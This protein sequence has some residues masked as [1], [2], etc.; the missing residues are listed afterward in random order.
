MLSIPVISM[1]IEYILLWYLYEYLGNP[2]NLTYN[3]IF[4]ISFTS[5]I[6]LFTMVQ[7]ILTFLQLE[8]QRKQYMP[9]LSAYSPTPGTIIIENSGGGPAWDIEVVIKSEDDVFDSVKKHYEVIYAKA[10]KLID[11][12]KTWDLNEVNTVPVT[13]D[14]SYF[15]DKEKEEKELWQGS[16]EVKAV[17]FL[18]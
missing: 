13:T 16:F 6:V 5:A 15:Y 7:I 12:T 8:S 17:Y 9:F 3:N 2:M 18:K 11:L 4:D 10:T 1:A 14:I